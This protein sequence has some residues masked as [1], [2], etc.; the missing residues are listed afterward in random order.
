MTDLATQLQYMRTLQGLASTVPTLASAPGMG[1]LGAG[2]GVASG[3]ESGT[4]MGNVRAGV[5][6]ARLANQLGAF[7]DN[8][9]AVAN[10]LGGL[11][12]ALGVYGGIKQG[13]VSGDVSAALNAAKLY[14]AAANAGV[15]GAGAA[16]GAGAMG[17]AGS[18][19]LGL[20]GTGV[21]GFASAAALP[22]AGAIALNQAFNHNS[23]Y[24]PQAYAAMARKGAQ[25][26]IT[27]AQLPYNQPGHPWVHQT[28]DQINAD[29]QS[30]ADMLNHMADQAL[31]GNYAN[32]VG[33]SGSQLQNAKYVKS[34]AQGG[35]M[36]NDIYKG[37]F[38]DRLQHFSE[39]GGGGGYYDSLASYFQGAIPEVTVPSGGGPYNMGLGDQG[40]SGYVQSGNGSTYTPG[41]INDP[42]T[43]A[44][45]GALSGMLGN[46]NALGKLWNSLG[47]G[48]Q[49]GTLGGLLAA[50]G[51]ATNNG[52]NMTSQ[53]HPN[54]QPMFA[55]T[56][57]HG[58]AQNATPATTANM[59]GHFSS[60]PQ[61]PTH[62]TVPS[63]YG[64]GP[65]LSFF[66]PGISPTTPVTLA[67]PRPTPV[68]HTPVAP[69]VRPPTVHPNSVRAFHIGNNAHGG[70]VRMA[71]GGMPGPM[72]N[73]P[74]M[75]GMNQAPN[76]AMMG[77]ALQGPSMMN[78]Q[79][80]QAPNAAS[81]MARPLQGGAPP[82]MA[83][84]MAGPLQGMQHPMM[85]GMRPMFGRGMMM[86]QGGESE[87]TT[88]GQRAQGLLSGPGD[89]TSDDIV[90]AALSAGEYV[91][92]A[93]VVSALGNGDNKAG[94]R[95][96]DAMQRNVRTKVGS[97]MAKNQHP[98][99][100]NRA[101]SPTAYMR[102]GK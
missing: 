19:A 93:H 22:V 11:T 8:T 27:T 42:S 49:V 7:G 58:T 60:I 20:G 26:A 97:A 99:G 62:P 41:D 3:L 5:S 74:N 15:L 96:L 86:A 77:G 51:S 39:G 56:G 57:P 91:V 72:M 95:A 85:G 59:Y 71:L 76:S 28:S 37:S 33:A 78:A 101:K 25:G 83:P 29:A 88:P 30:W 50:L 90:P 55:N 14:G 47:T 89:G 100:H 66:K 79:Q 94:A 67:P 9:G 40:D 87:E 2:L 24:S 36:S 70:P 44:K 68:N 43:L 31:S 4:P 98:T 65:A 102:G 48:S 52:S 12:G 38:K 92:P 13:G 64:E 32:L 81:M 16:S 84:R 61:V 54:P 23:N 45:S 17:T 6:G 73:A 53:Y 46:N 21:L 35:S 75:G 34:K 1:E 80:Q 10:G 63:N 18:G 69:V 82:P